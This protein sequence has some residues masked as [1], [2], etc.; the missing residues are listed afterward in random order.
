MST[1]LDLLKTEEKSTKPEVKH[2]GSINLKLGE[3]IVFSQRI[4]KESSSESS[5]K[6]ELNDLCRDNPEEAAKIL[7]KLVS[8][9]TVEVNL[10]GGDT[11]ESLADFLK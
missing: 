5:L 11:G 6:N 2:C 1:L 4:W 8:K 3:T 7:E 10:R 9:L